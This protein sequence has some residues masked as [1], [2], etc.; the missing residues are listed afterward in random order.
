M[1]LFPTVFPDN[2]ETVDFSWLQTICLPRCDVI[3]QGMLCHRA[4]EMATE[5]SFD[6]F[7]QVLACRLGIEGGTNCEDLHFTEFAIASTNRIVGVTVT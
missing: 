5:A 1:S 3:R 2:M 7:I 4:H 6:E